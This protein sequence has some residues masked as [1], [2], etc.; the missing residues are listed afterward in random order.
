MSKKPLYVYVH[1]PFCFSKCV[2]CDFL[3]FSG[4]KR[5]DEYVKALCRE[6]ISS[7]EKLAG[8]SVK[9]IYFGGGTPTVLEV[10]D[11]IK[12]KKS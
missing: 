11:L 12:I 1:I 3:S 9:S 7:A 4:N 6:I 2:Y 5:H 8:Y 10:G